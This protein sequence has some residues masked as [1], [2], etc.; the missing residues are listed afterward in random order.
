MS[1]AH[2]SA[3]CGDD[4]TGVVQEHQ[5]G[6]ATNPELGAQRCFSLPEVFRT[7]PRLANVQGGRERRERVGKELRN[8]FQDK[9]LE[10]GGILPMP[11]LTAG[12]YVGWVLVNDD[13]IDKNMN[14]PLR[15]FNGACRDSSGVQEYYTRV[16]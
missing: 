7:M 12:V 8:W 5:R 11:S 10:T 13:V 9:A 16:F 6:D 2:L 14:H 15:T 3:V 1:Y 4:G